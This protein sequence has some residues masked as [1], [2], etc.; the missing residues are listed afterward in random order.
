VLIPAG[1]NVKF[2]LF[3]IVMPIK[4]GEKR[5]YRKWHLLVEPAKSVE[6]KSF[7]YIY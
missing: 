4:L 1:N 5:Y 7:N 6:T 2:L 3:M